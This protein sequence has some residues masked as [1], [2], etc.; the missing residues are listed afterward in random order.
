MIINTTTKET[1]E[2]GL[3]KY[4]DIT[5]EEI[6]SHIKYAAEKT[7]ENNMDQKARAKVTGRREDRTVRMLFPPTVLPQSNVRKETRKAP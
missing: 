4:F 2:K 1:I 5:V 7:K 6:Y 3:A